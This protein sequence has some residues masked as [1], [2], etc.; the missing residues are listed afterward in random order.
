MKQWRIF[1]TISIT[2]III[3][4][5]ISLLSLMAM[6][7]ITNAQAITVAP[8]GLS[9][10]VIPLEQTKIARLGA[11]LVFTHTVTNSGDMADIYTILADDLENWNID[12]Q[13]DNLSLEPN[14]KGMFSVTVTIPEAASFEQSHSI[15]V[16]VKSQRDETVRK[17]PVNKIV[18]NHIAISPL[19]LTQ[20]IH[21]QPLTVTHVIT[22]LKETS[23]DTFT[24][25]V[26]TSSGFTVTPA[27]DNFNLEANKSVMLSTQITPIPSSQH[28]GTI[29][30][31][32]HSN[33]NDLVY[34]QAYVNIKPKTQYFLP[35]IRKPSAWN[36]VGTGDSTPNGPVI[37]MDV[38]QDTILA[39]ALNALWEYDTSTQNSSWQKLDVPSSKESS[40]LT[41]IV[42]TSDCQKVYISL[43][44]EGVL[45]G[46]RQNEGWKWESLSGGANVIHVRSMVLANGTLLAGG[47]SG[48]VYWKN[49][50]WEPSLLRESIPDFTQY[51]IMHL[52]ITDSVNNTG[53]VFA[54]QWV[55]P[56]VWRLFNHAPPQDGWQ[57]VTRNK[58]PNFPTIRTIAGDPAVGSNNFLVGTSD[59]LFLVTPEKGWEEILN[60]GTRSLMIAANNKTYAGHLDFKGV[61]VTPTVNEAFSS[62][63]HGWKPPEVVY[64]L[65]E[66]TDG[67]LY[68]ATTTGV[69]VYR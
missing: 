51:P 19:Q 50:S 32:I 43:Y 2:I 25:E 65:L 30:I 23:P 49:G 4:G 28:I 54:A 57:S 31:T 40:R 52:D 18:V 69:W 34:A 48:I 37:S 44:G 46:E 29:T 17:E 12:T 58:A 5:I 63:N 61:S 41:S 39:G 9:L 55:N 20:F 36:Q 1:L 62:H 16:I 68:A 3:T 47:D 60:N 35:I 10:E 38:C 8:N 45:K 22:N 64:E 21:T 11:Q 15:Q 59:K 33:T 24:V 66:G 56:T 26:N 27:S 13:P 7:H 6:P 14:E 42:F 53:T 67:A